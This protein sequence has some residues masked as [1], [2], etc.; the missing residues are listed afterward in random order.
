MRQLLA[1]E[2]QNA[3]AELGQRETAVA[4][5]ENLVA[6]AEKSQTARDADLARREQ[7]LASAGVRGF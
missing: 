3:R 5:R 6:E 2:T 4:D 1:D 7:H